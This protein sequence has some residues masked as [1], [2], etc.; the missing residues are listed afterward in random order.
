MLEVIPFYTTSEGQL[1]HNHVDAGEK[2]CAFS[3]NNNST[4]VIFG[5]M[6]KRKLTQS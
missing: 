2:N 6:K 1:F 3:N 4:F 5:R